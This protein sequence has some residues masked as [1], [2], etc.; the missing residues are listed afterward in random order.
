EV[1]ATACILG[2]ISYFLLL[3]TPLSENFVVV[4]SGAVVMAI[5]LLA[6]YF[7]LSL[8]NIYTKAERGED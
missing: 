8:P 2:G 5:R 4:I 6:V 7:D 1:Y 3:N